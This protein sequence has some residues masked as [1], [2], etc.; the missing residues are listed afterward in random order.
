MASESLQG[1]AIGRVVGG[2]YRLLGRLDG[3]SMGSVYEAADTKL[4]GKVVALKVMHRSLAGDT[5]VVKLLRQRFEEE[6]RLSAILGSHPRIIQV[7]DYGVEGPQPYLVMELL[8][9]RSLKE[10]LAQGP[11]PPGRAVRLAVQLCDGLQHA[12]AAQATVEGRT[13]RGIIHRDIKPG[14]LFLI[15]DE[16][17]GE[18]VKILDFGIAKANSDISLAL[19]TQAGFVGTSGYA[20]PEQLRGEALDARSDIYSLGVV[21]YQMLTG[22]MPLKPKTETFAGWYH[23]HN[24]TTPTGFQAHRL[25]Y[26]LPPALAAVVLSCLEK[27]PANRPQ[28]MQMLG[29]QLQWA[30]GWFPR[31]ETSQPLLPRDVFIGGAIALLALVG[32][33]FLL[34]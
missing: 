3:G 12:H 2:R 7:T 1:F 30:M 23:A 19:G 21:L 20:S 16:S 9:G 17:L 24:Y 6:A 11:M 10:V 4:A 28:S 33:L 8:K 31:E 22:Q 26:M 14:N 15:E 29:M 18:T 34:S 13:I 5:E 32:F 25:P 27:D